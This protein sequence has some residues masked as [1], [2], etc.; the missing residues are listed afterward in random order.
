M[1]PLDF[2]PD[3]F[4]SERNL[5]AQHGLTSAGLARARKTKRFKFNE[6]ASGKRVYLGAWFVEWL[7]RP[8]GE[9]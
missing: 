5:I 9:P 7:S 6:P 2:A 4:Y 3:R 8:E 1:N